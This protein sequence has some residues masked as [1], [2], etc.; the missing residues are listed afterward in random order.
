MKKENGITLIA[1]IFTI[2]VLIIIAAVAINLSLGN[3]GIFSRAKTAKEQYL[4]KQIDEE[5]SLANISNQIDG[6]NIFS[7][8]GFE[9]VKYFTSIIQ[10]GKQNIITGLENGKNYIISA[11]Y[12]IDNCESQTPVVSSIVMSNCEV[13]SSSELLYRYLRETNGGAYKFGSAMRT[14]YIKANSDNP[15]INV[16][17]T[18][19]AANANNYGFIT[20]YKIY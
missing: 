11:S 5:Y 2:V 10:S 7:S 14:F 9:N 18:D 1:L 19:T 6:D 13:I 16:T 12:Y 3:N 15:K 20:I 4:N 17:R 8:R